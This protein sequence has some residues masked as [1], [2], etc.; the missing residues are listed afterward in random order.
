MSTQ[1]NQWRSVSYGNGLFMVVAQ[2]WDN[3]T[4]M[5]STDNRQSSTSFPSPEQN[6]WRSITYG[7]GVFIALASSG[8]NR[9]MCSLDNGLTR[10]YVMSPEQNFLD[11]C[12]IWE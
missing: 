8:D 7:N 9:I 11:F 4:I 1:Q 10:Q 3:N 2:N 6:Q 12:S 5:R